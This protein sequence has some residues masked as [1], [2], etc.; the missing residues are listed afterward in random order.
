MPGQQEQLDIFVRLKDFASAQLKKLSGAFTSFGKLAASPF[1]A[2][3]NA[4]FSL[5][6]LLAGLGVA[7][8]AKGLFDLVKGVIDAGD[9]F[10]DMSR[11]L[12]VSTEFLSELDFA[13]Q[14]SGAS[15]DDLELGIKTATKNLT[16]FALTGGGAAADAMSL[17]SD[18]FRTAVNQGQGFEQLLPLLSREFKNLD[19]NARVLVASKIFGKGGAGLIPL[20]TD[21]MEALMKR[22]RDLGLT[23]SGEGARSADAFNDAL[24]ELSGALKGLWK[25][26][27]VPMLPE[28]KKLVEALTTK[29]VEHRRDVIGFFA[30]VVIGLGNLSQHLL[31]AAASGHE[32][33]NSLIDKAAILRRLLGDESAGL[34]TFSQF[35]QRKA[36]IESLRELGRQADATARTIAEAMRKAA[37]G[38]ESYDQQI[39]D[40]LKQPGFDEEAR[41]AAAA[42][43]KARGEIDELRGSILELQELP[44]IPLADPKQFQFAAGAK[45]AID[46]LRTEFESWG[47]TAHDTIIG[48]HD[49][50]VDNISD[51]LSNVIDGTKSLGQAFKDMAKGILSDIQRII[52]KQL[53][54][55]AV[56]GIFGSFG[57]KA[58]AKGGITPPLRPIRGLAFGGIVAPPGGLFAVGEGRRSEAV[59]PLPDNRS[60]PVRFEG[61]GAGGMTLI[62]NNNFHHSFVSPL[63]ERRLLERNKATIVNAVAEANNSSL[64]AREALRS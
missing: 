35:R 25:S 9:K 2:L 63:E 27:I 29:L 33:I 43:R 60:I 62:Q 10:N 38:V 8:T 58:V 55:K 56:S 61:R 46:D 26:I 23:F 44:P 32:F 48:V 7:L 21:D 36:E 22:A 4:V 24:G 30:D 13:A 37:A 5:K 47:K 53:V 59:V 57:S 41:R 15:L 14:Q 64:R 20:L 40:L 3:A 1:K 54:L 18:S 17:L 12:G 16:E 6:G 34:M 52:V 19:A 51:E 31:N 11:A 42:A 39:E 45:T 50:L 28:L 49:A